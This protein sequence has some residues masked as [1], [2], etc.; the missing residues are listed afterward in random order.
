MVFPCFYNAPLSYYA[1]LARQEGTVL[2]ELE[3]HYSKQTYRNRCRIMGAND[4]I[5]LVI[6]VVKNHGRKTPMGRVQIDYDTNWRHIHWQSITSS[7]A[8]A[9]FFEFYEDVY[10]EIYDR[11]Y[12]Y[13]AELNLDLLRVTLDALDLRLDIQ[14]TDEYQ[15][16]D[17]AEDLSE[18]IHPK[19]SF[20][21]P[22]WEV[23]PEEYH[24]VFRNRLGFRENLSILDLIFN[25]G[26][27]ALAYLKKV[28]SGK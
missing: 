21:H 9:P 16:Q 11:R 19:R 17:K 1:L 12:Q 18:V 15:V 26:P 6:P 24:Q 22:R 8:S 20:S 27:N 4:V 5:D 23:H 10:R 25:E 7:Y 14:I 3:D 13:L 2:I 28:I